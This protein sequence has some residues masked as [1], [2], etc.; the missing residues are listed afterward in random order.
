M[1][2]RELD[3]N[4]VVWEGSIDIVDAVISAMERL[5]DEA[6]LNEC[7]DSLLDLHGYTFNNNM[8]YERIKDILEKE[9]INVG[10]LNKKINKAIFNEETIKYYAYKE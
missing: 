7:D 10:E 9:G 6:P 4:K 5:D 3:Y 8:S 1:K 2:E